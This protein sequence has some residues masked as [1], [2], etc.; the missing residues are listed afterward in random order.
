MDTGLFASWKEV[1]IYKTALGTAPIN[2]ETTLGGRSRSGVWSRG[3]LQ[4]PPSTRKQEILWTTKKPSWFHIL[5][6]GGISVQRPCLRWGRSRVLRLDCNHRWATRWQ[7]TFGLWLAFS[8]LFWRL[9][10]K[11]SAAACGEVV[12]KWLQCDAVLIKILLHSHM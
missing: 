8:L 4:Q 3:A 12:V 1:K 5:Y 10:A 7:L 9:R 2:T 11:V 6:L